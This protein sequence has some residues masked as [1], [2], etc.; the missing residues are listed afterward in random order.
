MKKFNA[1]GLQLTRRIILIASLL[2]FIY[3]VTRAALLSFTHDESFTFLEY[4]RGSWAK[5]HQMG[6]TNN[7]LL[8]SWLM[9]VCYTLFGSSE[10]VLRL[11]NVL[12]HGLFLFFSAKL[13]FNIKNTWL[14]LAGWLFVNLDPFM[15]DFFS[16]ARGYGISLGLLMMGMYG[17]YQ[18]FFIAN[19]TRNTL[20]AIVPVC[21][22]VLANLTLVNFLLAFLAVIIISSFLIRKNYISVGVY[23][24]GS[25]IR[26]I[27]ITFLCAGLTLKFVLPLLFNLKNAGNFDFGGTDGF[28]DDTVYT[29]IKATLYQGPLHGHWGTVFLQAL[30]LI[31]I[32]IFT[33]RWLRSLTLRS[34]SLYLDPSVL[35]FSLIA[36]CSAS[37][38]FQHHL[39]KIPFSVD[40]AAIYFIPLFAMFTTFLLATLS[41]VWS[42]N[43]LA[44]TY[45]IS[46]LVFFFAGAN[47]TY[48]Y[49]WTFESSVKEK[50]CELRDELKKTDPNEQK[51]IGVDFLY[52]PAFN[53]YRLRYDLENVNATQHD[54]QTTTHFY[55]HYLISAETVDSFGTIIGKC[56]WGKACLTKN[57][58]LPVFKTVSMIGPVDFETGPAH[59][60][61]SVTKINDAYDGNCAE[62][63]DPS[64]QYSYG[65][66]DTIRD[67]E[68][69]KH[70]TVQIDAMI[71]RDE[72]WAEGEMII[73][74]DRKGEL[75]FWKTMNI[76][77]YV[78]EEK[79]WSHSV[80]SLLLPDG[81]QY[82][83][84][85]STYIW[86][87]GYGRLLVDHLQCRISSVQF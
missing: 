18:L 58:E 8:N 62:I 1:P 2:L 15:L 43:V 19:S 74:V 39:F 42:R 50:M 87:P 66:T 7:H 45:S 71:R 73:S 75:F 86:N 70:V 33:W 67:P 25:W 11:P 34:F 10:F 77:E 17:L 26:V 64:N 80:F 72:Y 49:L 82:G 31:P 57:P 83:D 35:Y 32:A 60:R 37:L 12:S 3:S 4:V 68:N 85:I 54:E 47:L 23:H 51:R 30:I 40:R 21:L 79:K 9:K 44:L 61:P 13:L 53:Y 27:V 52:K 14:V 63:V 69:Y 22:A 29:L 5:V 16:L 6:F 24:R 78:T 81:L 65:L 38:L 20:F 56:D 28:W 48:T 46:S 36:I 76:R 59:L 55:D 84:R 41:K